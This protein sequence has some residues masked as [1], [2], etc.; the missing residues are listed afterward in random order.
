[1]QKVS[2][3]QTQRVP[4]EPDSR[5][6]T[7][8][9]LESITCNFEHEVGKGG[10]GTVYHGY[11]DGGAEVAVKMRSQ[12]SSQGDK[13]FMTEVNDPTRTAMH[14]LKRFIKS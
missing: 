13:E 8:K 2:S 14:I 12:S 3:G 10:F 7:Y 11:L 6:F 4:F 5:Q 1:M 9:E